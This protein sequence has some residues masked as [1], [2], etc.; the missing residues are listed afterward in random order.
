MEK[1]RVHFWDALLSA[2]AEACGNVRDNL[3]DYYKQFR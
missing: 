1:K 2:I 3:T